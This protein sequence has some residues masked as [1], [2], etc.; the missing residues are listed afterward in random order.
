MKAKG[1]IRCGGQYLELTVN[2]SKT[3]GILDKMAAITQSDCLQAM[4]QHRDSLFLSVFCSPLKV[5]YL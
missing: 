3:I 1:K 4:N 5:S 2:S